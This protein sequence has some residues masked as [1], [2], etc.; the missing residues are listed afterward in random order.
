MAYVIT[1]MYDNLITSGQTR[2]Q[3]IKAIEVHGL[4]I[5]TLPRLPRKGMEVY[6]VNPLYRPSYI[7]KQ[8]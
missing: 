3:L 2:A 6:V 5:I 4:D 1:D 8:A 7:I